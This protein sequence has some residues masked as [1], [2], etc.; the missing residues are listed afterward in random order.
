MTQVEAELESLKA[1]VTSQTAAREQAEAVCDRQGERITTLQSTVTDLEK[2]V[3]EQAEAAAELTRERDGY[4][5]QLPTQEDEAALAELTNLLTTKR[6]PSPMKSMSSPAQSG[7]R[8]SEPR[9]EA[10]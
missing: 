10:A 3:T 2:R 9:A 4:R 6:I 5:A 7:L 8:I 1:R